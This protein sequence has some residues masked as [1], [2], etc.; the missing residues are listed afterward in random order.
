MMDLRVQP[1][2]VKGV[3]ISG[4]E[5][6]MVNCL[7]GAIEILEEADSSPARER[8]YPKPTAHDDKANAEWQRLVASELRHLFVTA[9]E[10]VARDLTALKADRRNPALSEL[11]FP[12]EHVNAWMSVLNGARLVLGAVFDVTEVD[13]N[14]V[15]FEVLDKRTIGV[16]KIHLLGHLLQLF[17]QLESGESAEPSDEPETSV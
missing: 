13:M 11:C 4:I 3:R 1:E 7:L 14:A 12:A 6:Y 16:M 5:P 17:V 9:G 10:T 8:L 15:N 2:G